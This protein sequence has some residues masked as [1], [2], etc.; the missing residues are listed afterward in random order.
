MGEEL[1]VTACRTS[2]LYG[3][4]YSRASPRLFPGVVF[5]SIRYRPHGLRR[6]RGECGYSVIGKCENLPEKL[7]DYVKN[8]LEKLADYVKIIG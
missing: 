7:A 8:I 5:V 1:S 3:V 6:A 2:C 4:T